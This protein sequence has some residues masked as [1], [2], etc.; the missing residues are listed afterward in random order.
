MIVLIKNMLLISDKH[1]VQSMQVNML[2]AGALFFIVAHIYIL[3][4]YL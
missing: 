1:S 4:Q 3:V 2:G